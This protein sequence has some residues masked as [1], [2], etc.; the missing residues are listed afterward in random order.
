MENQGQVGP[1]FYNRVNF[2]IALLIS[3]LLSIVP[4]LTWRGT[5]GRELLRKLI[6]PGIFALIVAVA[7]AVWQVHNPFHL[8]FVFLAAL[9]LATNLD[10][11]IAKTR[12]GGLRGAGGYLAHVG[13]GVILLGIIASS[14]Y[15]RSAKV[16]L[17][18]GVPS[19]VGDLTLTFERFIPR[20]GYEREKME[21]QV[22]KADGQKFKVY[23]R[24][25]MNERT[26]QVMVHPD[27]RKTPLQDLY[28]SPIDF[29]PGR[30]SLQLAQGEQ[31]SVGNT[32]IRFVSFDLN[33]DGNAIAQM[34]G[35]KPITI[36]AV[37]D[38]TRGGQTSRVKPLY[39]LNPVDG[40]VETPPLA[41]PGGGHIYVAGINAS[42]RAVQVGIEGV[43]SRPKLSV[44]VTHKPLINLVWWGLYVVLLGGILS[45]VQRIREV[46][47]RDRLAVRAAEE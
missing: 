24:L 36:G 35:G 4:Y 40:S 21:V 23:P 16:T 2:P 33:A 18:Q 39:R 5:A 6:V 8:L 46:R 25:F 12:A 38:V 45:T 3:V 9:A 14:A 1:E 22:V 17:E 20:Q 42:S 30:P 47:L 11:T 7:A 19:Q 29:D 13:V 28:V 41:L 27:I 10:K 37:F 43:A 15:D 26:K 44:D 34:E 31:G 32:Q